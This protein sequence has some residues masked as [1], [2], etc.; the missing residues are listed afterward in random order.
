M[1]HE[2]LGINN[3]RI[4]LSAVPGISKDMHDVVLS[5]EHDEFYSRVNHLLY[6]ALQL[7][8]FSHVIEFLPFILLLENYYFANDYYHTSD[9]KDKWC[10]YILYKSLIILHYCITLP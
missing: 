1:V 5:S 6:I 8:R 2:L 10:Y 9:E 4:N 3:S 7:L